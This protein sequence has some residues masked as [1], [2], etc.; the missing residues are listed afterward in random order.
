MVL[1]RPQLDNCPSC[2]IPAYFDVDQNTVG[3]LMTANFRI[4]RK[5]WVKNA[6]RL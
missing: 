2:L 4:V 3:D 1:F 5:D 6:L